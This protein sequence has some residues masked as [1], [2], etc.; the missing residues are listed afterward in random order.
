MAALNTLKGAVEAEKQAAASQILVDL[1]ST[2]AEG[3]TNPAPSLT[4]NPVP[5]IYVATQ[6]TELIVFDG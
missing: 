2:P 6:P 1:L 3:S 5:K 4:K